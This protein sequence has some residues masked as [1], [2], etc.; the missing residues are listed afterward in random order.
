MGRFKTGKI[1]VQTEDQTPL[2][3]LSGTW[4]VVRTPTNPFETV[5][6][7]EVHVPKDI[8]ARTIQSAF[9]V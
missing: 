7:A 5:T 4:K 9:D 8:I 1:L 6:D 2:L 3:S